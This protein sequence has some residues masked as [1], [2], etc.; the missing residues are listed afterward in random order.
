MSA[1]YVVTMPDEQGI[2]NELGSPEPGPQIPEH[3]QKLASPDAAEQLAAATWFRQLLVQG[4]DSNE[5]AS[6]SS[7]ETDEDE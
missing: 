7:S 6:A 3:A 1:T 2:T 4:G 5:H